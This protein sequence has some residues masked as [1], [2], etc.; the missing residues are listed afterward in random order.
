MELFNI[1]VFGFQFM[2]GVFAAWFVVSF[3]IW[4]LVRLVGALMSW[5]NW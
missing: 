3:I 1:F 5:R 4:L 2:L